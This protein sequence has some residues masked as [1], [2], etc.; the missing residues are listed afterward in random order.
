[1]ASGLIFLV[2]LPI[3]IP[4]SLIIIPFLAGRSGARSLP[5]NW[6]LT[7]IL[8]VGGGWSIGLALLLFSILFLVLGPTLK[9][10]IVEV[11]ILAVIIVF[12]W[13]SFFIGTKSVKEPD[14]NLV[15][16]AEEWDQFEEEAKA[17]IMA[18]ISNERNSAIDKF[19]NFFTDK[20]SKEES[21]ATKQ[22]KKTNKAKATSTKPKAS[23]V[24]ALASRR[25]K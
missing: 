12:S 21:N 11:I 14:E 19:K 8:T 1:M 17:P 10:G 20:K 13:G 7:Y 18:E 4:V 23:R 15:K 24:S 3:G 25:R 16:N 6:H 22:D 2:F 5:K 9:I